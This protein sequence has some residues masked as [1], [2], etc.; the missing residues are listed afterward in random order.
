MIGNTAAQPKY[1]VEDVVIPEESSVTYTDCEV[2]SEMP[3]LVLV[4]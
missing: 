3:D 2:A 1:E 4:M